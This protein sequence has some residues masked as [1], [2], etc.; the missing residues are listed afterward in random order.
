MSAE[1]SSMARAPKSIRLPESVEQE[2]H[3]LAAELGINDSVIFRESIVRN[4]RKTALELA[5]EMEVS[6]SMQRKDV[7]R[8]HVRRRAGT[9]KATV[10]VSDHFGISLTVARSRLAIGDVTLGGNVVKPDDQ[11]TD[12]EV[13]ALILA[14]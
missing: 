12:A 8:R 1:G 6:A 14:Q 10:A 3:E 7:N 5:R 9:V 11:L 4:Y 2:I 13:L